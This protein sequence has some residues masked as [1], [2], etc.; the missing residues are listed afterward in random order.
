MID[1]KMGLNVYALNFQLRMFLKIVFAKMENLCKQVNVLIA[2]THVGNVYQEIKQTIA[3]IVI[4]Q[5]N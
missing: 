2:I 4:I 1:I 5:E 3:Q